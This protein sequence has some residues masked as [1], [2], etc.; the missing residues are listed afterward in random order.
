[1]ITILSL[2]TGLMAGLYF[3]FSFVVVQALCKL[4][5]TEGAKA[6]N[7]IN[8]VIVKTWFMPLFLISSLWYAGLLIWSIFFSHANQPHII[9]ACVFY[10]G[11]MLGVT[12]F[13]NVPLN[14][15][16]KNCAHDS[17]KLVAAW[18]GYGRKWVALNHVRTASCVVAF[19]L[20]NYAA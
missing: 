2:L 20:L 18:N 17:N 6:M 9:W 4:P 11:G 5:G 7:S 14:N 10:L 1:M 15:H 12:A 19:M 13:C 16:L 8:N 3:A